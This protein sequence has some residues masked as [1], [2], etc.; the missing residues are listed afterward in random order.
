MSSVVT[1]I[2]LWPQQSH[3]LPEVVQQKRQRLS[4][5]QEPGLNAAHLTPWRAP[6]VRRSARGT[7][8]SSQG[9]RSGQAAARAPRPA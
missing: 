4:R 9:V 1:S 3:N 7:D 5:N 8:P 6:S 2:S